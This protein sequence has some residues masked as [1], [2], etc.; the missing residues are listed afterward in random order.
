LGQGGFGITYLARDTNL[1][2]P[3]AIKEFLP[4]DLAVRTHDSSVE[5]LS[6]GHSDTFGWGLKRFITEAQTLAKFRHPNIVLVYSVFEANNTAYMVMEYVEGRTLEDALRFKK[7]QGEADFKRIILALLDG[8]ELIHN[9]GFI[10]RDIKPENIYVREDG[11]PVLLDFGSARQAVGG[12]TRTLTALV[13]PGYAPYEQYDSSRGGETK[14]GPWT[15]VYALGATLYRAVSGNG[16]IDAMARVNAAMAGEDL[17]QRASSIG[18]SAY[19]PTFLAAID[20]A[21]AL[22]PPDRP[23]TIDVW[24]QALAGQ[25]DREIETQFAKPPK[26]GRALP[27]A[28]DKTQ[29]TT[30][31]TGESAEAAA[32]TRLAAPAARRE[33][34]V[35]GLSAPEAPAR[36]HGLRIPLFTALALA[37]VVGVVLWRSE[38]PKEVDEAIPKTTA[39]APSSE[40]AVQQR[41]EEAKQ[42]AEA[43]ARIEAEQAKNAK[44]TSLLALAEEDFE[45]SRLLA[46]AKTNALARYQEVLVLE[47]DRAEA[48]AGIERIVATL[49]QVATV[50]EESRKYAEA[51]RY[52]DEAERIVP[53]SKAVVDARTALAEAKA[54]YEQELQRASQ[55]K[56][57]HAE[58]EAKRRAEQERQEQIE[59][60]LADAD[61]DLKARRLTSPPRVNAFE[62]YQSVLALD[63]DNEAAH[64]GL[65]KIVERYLE[66]Q[67]RAVQQKDFQKAQGYLDKAGAILPDSERLVGAKA[68]LAAAR[69]EHEAEQAKLAAQEAQRL[70]E[71]SARV[72]AEAEQLAKAQ[73]EAEQLEAA[74]ARA[75]P[76]PS[77]TAPSPPEKRPEPVV[78]DLKTAVLP[79][80]Y[81]REAG[82]SWNR[83]KENWNKKVVLRHLGNSYGILKVTH[84]FGNGSLKDSMLRDVGK[85]WVT[86]KASRKEPNLDLIYERAAQL[87]VDVVVMVWLEPERYVGQWPAEYYLIDVTNRR[88]FHQKGMAGSDGYM[89]SVMSILVGKLVAARKETY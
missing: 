2:Q 85:V 16:P 43:A 11:T 69:A 79:L 36:K 7:I 60:L 37:V 88:V 81:R 89:G 80:A 64:E 76:P 9:E 87:P 1:N 82:W 10:H 32:V 57:E 71:E 40:E 53:G 13:S 30:F 19:S 55:A 38:L 70:E 83:G 44:I 48:K 62:R 21:L 17:F 51:E 58:A 18:K 12:K 3:V 20:W 68:E 45:A 63:P 75:Q 72:E 4:S 41:A 27:P 56:R 52:L 14:Q 84:A 54:E 50:L 39:D 31:Q 78:R 15:D 35:P 26:V 33:Q 28:A 46:P 8:L 47:P 5:P 24:R 23:Q 73:A 74:Q 22:R 66:F 49:M 77:D 25:I 61:E 65:L 86:T 42:R 59:A 34:P 67:D 6:D 29:P